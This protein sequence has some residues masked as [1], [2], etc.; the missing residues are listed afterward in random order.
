MDFVSIKEIASQVGLD[1]SSALK[2]IKRAGLRL[3]QHR[4]SDSGSQRAACLTQAD[5]QL[6]VS[7]REQGGWQPGAKSDGSA[8][9]DV[10]VFYAIALAPGLTPDIK[11]GFTEDATRRLAEHRTAAPRAQLL[12]SWPCRRSWEGTAIS[13]VTRSDC[14]FMGGECFAFADQ[15]LAVERAAAFFALL[16]NP[17]FQPALD[18]ASFLNT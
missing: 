16:P 5:A 6:F 18:D 15:G 12:G 9:S 4:F 14:T 8:A 10:G 1:R 13:S 7:M 11:L 17:D 3:H 2:A